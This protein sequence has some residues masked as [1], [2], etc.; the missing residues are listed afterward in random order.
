M[1]AVHPAAIQSQVWIALA[2]G[3]AAAVTVAF[4]EG[5]LLATLLLSGVRLPTRVPVPVSQQPLVIE[6]T[7]FVASSPTPEDVP[8]QQALLV[9]PSATPTQMVLPTATPWP[10]AVPTATPWHTPIPPEPTLPPAPAAWPP[11]F[12]GNIAEAYAA[13]MGSNCDGGD[14]PSLRAWLYSQPV[15]ASGQCDTP[16][17]FGGIVHT[18]NGRTCY[19]WPSTVPTEMGTGTIVVYRDEGGQI[20][21]F[22]VTSLTVADREWWKNKP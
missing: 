13:G 22:R 20:F 2:F 12:D 5:V 1:R 17:G 9:L 4:L 18:P 11:V 7:V 10:T 14:E 16:T 8:T 6:S 21:W 19:W 3:F 15:C